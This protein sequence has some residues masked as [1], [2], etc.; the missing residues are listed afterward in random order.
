[1][2]NNNK[3]TP[4]IFLVISIILFVIAWFLL[5][6]KCTGWNLIN[7]LCQLGNI[8]MAIIK[9]IVIAIAILMFAISMIYLLFEGTTRYILLFLIMLIIAVVMWII[10]DPVPFIDE[11]IASIM[12]FWYALKALGINVNKQVKQFEF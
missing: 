2:S 9:T 1:M 8:T 11:I 5:D 12:T 3:T 6:I 10:P 7:P 4:L